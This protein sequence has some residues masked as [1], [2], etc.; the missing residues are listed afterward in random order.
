MTH[1]NNGYPPTMRPI[2]AFVSDELHRRLVAQAQRERIRLSEIIRVA[3]ENELDRRESS[4]VGYVDLLA[5]Y[6]ALGRRHRTRIAADGGS[7]IG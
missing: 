6:D 5:D 2:Q 3:V 1:P 7:E 4:A